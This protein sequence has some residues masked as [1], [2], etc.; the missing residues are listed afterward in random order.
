MGKYFLIGIPDCGKSTLG[1]LAADILKL[2]FFDTD[3]MVCDLLDFKSAA[4]LFRSALNQSFLNAQRAVLDK[5]AKLDSDAIIS[6][7]AEVSLVPD[8]VRQMHALGTI[9]HI[10]RNPE[11]IRE[12]LKNRKTSRIV[13][14]DAK[15]GKEIDAQQDIVKLY[16]EEYSKYEAIADLSFENN[17]SEN[18]GVQK[19]VMLINKCQ[20]KK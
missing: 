7:G 8:C 19:L 18:E 16:M 20:A 2:Q 6:T 15:T 1:K 5:I 17:G 12:K 13:F 4:D 11:L 14:L 10:K 3:I 9:I